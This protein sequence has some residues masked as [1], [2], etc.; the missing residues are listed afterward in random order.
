M[1]FLVVEDRILLYNGYK[2]KE[3]YV[4]FRLWGLG[5]LGFGFTD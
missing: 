5:C 4:G 1:F 3:G 2:G